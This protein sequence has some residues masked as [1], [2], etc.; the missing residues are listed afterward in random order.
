[1][2][3]REPGL[4]SDRPM[5]TWVAP[6]LE[7]W[8]NWLASRFN[9]PVYLVGSALVKERP[10][11]VDIRVIMPD[12]EFCQRYGIRHWTDTELIGW[13]VSP[14]EVVRFHED[15]AH[16][17]ALATKLHSKGLNFDV[18]V[19]TVEQQQHR[20]LAAGGPRPRIR[21]DRLGV[22]VPIGEEP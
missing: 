19:H 4:T 18:Q 7:G 16:L 10:R 1:M 8:A 15:M 14:P 3:D 20:D 12:D 17:N 13:D 9:A 5:A 6:L 22:P 21:L 2:A 11:D